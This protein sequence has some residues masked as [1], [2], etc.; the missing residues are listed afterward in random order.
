MP[1]YRY[2]ARTA[3]PITSRCSRGRPIS[4]RNVVNKA[5]AILGLWYLGQE[6]GSAVANALFGDINPGGKLPVNK[7]MSDH[8]TLDRINEGFDLMHEG[9][10]IRSVVVF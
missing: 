4:A 9:K 5:A 3:C 1:Q 6:N 8:L 2:I 7:L 10:S